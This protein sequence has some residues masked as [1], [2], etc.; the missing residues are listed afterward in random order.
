MPA[1]ERLKLDQIVQ[2]AHK[3]GRRVRFWATPDQPS[4]ARETLWR[5]LLTTGVDVLNTDDLKGLQQFLLTYR[6][7]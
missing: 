3:K 4:P 5:I 2:K 1:K 7:K 6:E